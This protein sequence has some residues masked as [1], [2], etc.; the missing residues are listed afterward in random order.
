MR[1]LVTGIAYSPRRHLLQLLLVPAFVLT[2]L[3]L[4]FHVY[5]LVTDSNARLEFSDE[6]HPLGK[7]GREDLTSLAPN[8]VMLRRVSVPTG[9]SKSLSIVPIVVLAKP[10]IPLGRICDYAT[11]L[12][13]VIQQ[14]LG[15]RI[16]PNGRADPKTLRYAG[17]ASKHRVNNQLGEPWFKNIYLLDDYTSEVLFASK[18]CQPVPPHSTRW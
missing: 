18:K 7:L 5:G 15:K 17:I 3:F 9:S 4:S 1:K 13:L 8:G 10:D 14:E 2:N 12:T 16:R 11:N 6:G